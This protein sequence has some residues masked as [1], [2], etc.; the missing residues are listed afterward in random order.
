MGR[1]LD[2]NAHADRRSFFETG[3]SPKFSILKK[4]CEAQIG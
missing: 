1:V 3:K 2:W 4:H